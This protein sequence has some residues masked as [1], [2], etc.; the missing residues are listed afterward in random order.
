[1]LKDFTALLDV[2]RGRTTGPEKNSAQQSHT[3]MSSSHLTGFIVFLPFVLMCFRGVGA[4][5]AGGTFGAGGAFSLLIFF[6]CGGYHE[7]HHL[8]SIFSFEEQN[9]G[10]I[11]FYKAG[12][13]R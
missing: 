11:L 5:G 10:I 9:K 8:M 7:A 1:M 12:L 3:L 13:Y 2:S 4:F 6:F